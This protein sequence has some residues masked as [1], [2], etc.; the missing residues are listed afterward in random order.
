MSEG[1]QYNLRTRKKVDYSYSDNSGFRELK[2]VEVATPKARSKSKAKGTT[3]PK[4]RSKLKDQSSTKSAQSSASKTPRR[5]VK[6][7]LVYLSSDDDFVEGEF[8]NK[9]DSTFVVENSATNKSNQTFDAK[10][11]LHSEF[12]IPH[13]STRKRNTKESR[14]HDSTLYHS[15]V[16]SSDL[17]QEIYSTDD[18]PDSTVPKFGEISPIQHEEPIRFTNEVR[19]K[20]MS[21]RV[22]RE[23]KPVLTRTRHKSKQ[24]VMR[25]FHTNLK[26]QIF[27][28]VLCLIAISALAVAAILKFEDVRSTVSSSRKSRL[29]SEMEKLKVQFPSQTFRFWNVLGGAS[30]SHVQQP[31]HVERPI[32]VLLAGT[33]ESAETMRCLAKKVAVMFDTMFQ[34]SKDPISI[35][36]RNYIDKDSDQVKLKI[37][38]KLKAGFNSGG[39]TAVIHYVDNLPPCSVILFHSYCENENAPYKDVAI[40]LTLQLGVEDVDLDELKPREFDALASK[41]LKDRWKECVE[42]L[43]PDKQDALLSRVANNI[44]RVKAEDKYDLMTVCH[45]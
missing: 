28:S 10:R 17:G 42:E 23:P 29:E 2:N 24:D 19:D 33:T 7:E 16:K 9:K 26:W 5:K 34:S 20:L 31:V 38:T 6:A 13:G 35:S 30:F 45:S 27:G 36:G 22:S 32:V 8:E 39:K 21:G 40:I 12:K 41:H 37:D 43:T 11:E 15:I 25:E 18:E 44:A 1:R 3:T 14:N 4:P